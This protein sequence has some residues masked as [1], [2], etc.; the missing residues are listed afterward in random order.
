MLQSS[1]NPFFLGPALNLTAVVT[2]PGAAGTVYFY[3]GVVPIGA[4]TLAGG[5]AV[6]ST[7]LL[8]P[9]IHPLTAYYRG[10][11]ANPSSTSPV[12]SQTV[13][14]LGQSGFQP[15]VNFGGVTN[16]REAA[17]GDF[18]GDGKIDLVVA[19]FG[20]NSIAVMLG[21]GDGTFQPPLS[22]PT[23]SAQFSG[24]T[25]IV[26]TDFNGDGRMDIAVVNGATFVNTVAVLL[27]NGDGTFR[28]EMSYA[29]PGNPHSLIAADFN[30][31]GIPDL[32]TDNFG[33]SSV[34]V[35]LGKG[36]GTFQAAV[37]VVTPP[38]PLNLAAGDFNGDGRPDI[39]VVNQ[40]QVSILLGIGDGTFRSP[41][42]YA[43]GKTA[44][45]VAVGDLNGDGRADLVVANIGDNNV[46]VLLG[47]GDGTFQN[48]VNYAAGMGPTTIAIRDFNG[49]GLP[50][51]AVTDAVGNNV[52]ILLGNG[53]GTL[54]APASY[55]TGND[56]LALVA[57][58]FNG[59]GRT[60]LAVGNYLAG[61]ISV[62]LGVQVSEPIVSQV[63]NGASFQNG[64]AANA[65][66][67]I[68]GANLSSATDTWDK[69]IVNGQLPVVLD[70]VSVTVGGQPA[71]VYF[72]S[73][74]QINVVAP[75]ISQGTVKVIV[76]SPQGSSQAFMV[77]PQSDQPAFFLW[78]S[79]YAVATRQDFTYAAKNGTF[80]GLATVPAKPGDVIILWGTGFGPTSPPAPVGV[81]VPAGAFPTATPV[82]V[83]LGNV[84][85]TVIGAARA[86]GF[87]ALFQVAIQIPL[88][89]P[90]GDYPVVAS[91]G[92]VSSPAT[93][94]LSVMQ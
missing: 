78:N 88:S 32:A 63:Q 6:L 25:G 49:D 28:P 15:A 42:N 14:A 30:G 72:I 38:S 24:P 46:S 61:N 22:Y 18:N 1:G 82:T 35:L 76:K 26:V 8:G 83:M 7:V 10:D 59:D 71:Y 11:T 66:V 16:P 69:A 17:A 80:T 90:D 40:T 57:A 79:T 93:A 47:K 86:P 41:V 31:D 3:D 56:P 21:K 52:S 29:V 70:G 62:L 50:D 85:A 68:R 23:D 84:P 58:D 81:Q 87:A 2:P 37:N 60:D 19:N 55:G 94:L 27:G 43:V 45:K 51:I 64:L 91:I 65:W 48:A 77:T 75:D 44:A 73:P 20:L 89:L 92:G 67:T 5:Q 36:D 33:H 13:L 4:G 34:A 12:L 74:A 53:D 54:Q 9:G 39:A